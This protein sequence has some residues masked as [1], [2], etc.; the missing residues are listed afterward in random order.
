MSIYLDSNY[1][2]DA[3][4]QKFAV[5]DAESNLS[6]WVSFVD[7]FIQLGQVCFLVVAGVFGLSC[8]VLTLLSFLVLGFCLACLG[9]VFAISARCRGFF[10][11]RARVFLQQGV[12][13][14]FFTLPCA[15]LSRAFFICFHVSLVLGNLVGILFPEIGRTFR[16]VNQMVSSACLVFKKMDLV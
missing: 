1:G 10:L 11:I 5:F 7:V 6:R 12:N 4:K 13:G 8:L 3:K 15:V 16:L 14:L 9:V 2:I